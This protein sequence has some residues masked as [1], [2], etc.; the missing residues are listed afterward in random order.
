MSAEVLDALLRFD[1]LLAE[2]GKTY[3]NPLHWN[4]R[5]YQSRTAA[6]WRSGQA[7][8][9]IPDSTNNSLQ[10]LSRRYHIELFPCDVTAPDLAQGETAVMF[11]WESGEFQKITL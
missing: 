10:Y 8:A 5:E 9:Y 6:F 7:A 2:R 1:A 3:P 4:G 11:K